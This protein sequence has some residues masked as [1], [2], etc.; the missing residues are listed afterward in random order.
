MEKNKDAKLRNEDEVVG[1]FIQMVEV[2]LFLTSKRIVHRDLKPAN[3]MIRDGNIVL[4]DLAFQSK[5][6]KQLLKSVL[7]VVLSI[8]WHLKFFHN[9]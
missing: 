9:K 7:F 6:L 4:I 3:F 8:I 5:V 2:V 1:F